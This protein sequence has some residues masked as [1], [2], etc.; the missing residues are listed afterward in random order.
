[1]HHSEACDARGTGSQRSAGKACK[2]FVCVS[3]RH[4]MAGIRGA[5]EAGQRK[6]L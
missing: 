3:E 6:D 5:L 2:Y 1:M 4:G